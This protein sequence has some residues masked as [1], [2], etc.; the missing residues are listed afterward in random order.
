[1]APSQSKPFTCN[2]EDTLNN[3][4][5]CNMPV[6]YEVRIQ[7]DTVAY[8]WIAFCARHTKSIAKATGAKKQDIRPVKIIR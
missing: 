5:I 8:S 7:V 3:Q 4:L 6:K 1:L 2:Y